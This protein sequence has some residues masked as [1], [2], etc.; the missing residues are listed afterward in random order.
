MNELYIIK[1]FYKGRVVHERLALEVLN[2]GHVVGFTVDYND[3][4]NILVEFANGDRYN[5][6]PEDLQAL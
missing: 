1:Q 6:A 4:V 5:V 2:P 3:K